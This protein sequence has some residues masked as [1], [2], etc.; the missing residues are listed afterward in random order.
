MPTGRRINRFASTIDFAL[1]CNSLCH[2]WE[3]EW[4]RK[5]LK[6]RNIKEKSRFVG[7]GS[8]NW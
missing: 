3:L 6:T 7:I 1:V 4:F 8:L 2:S 5:R